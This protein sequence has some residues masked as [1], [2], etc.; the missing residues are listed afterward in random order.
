MTKV[1]VVISAVLLMTAFVFAADQTAASAGQSDANQIG[2]ATRP[3]PFEV[4]DEM[5]DRIMA[6]LSEQEPEKAKEL[7]KLRNE[8]KAKFMEQ[9]SQLFRE[10]M[11]ERMRP[12]RG[13]FGEEEQPAAGGRPGFH[14]GYGGGFG[15]QAGTGPNEVEM[16]NFMNMFRD[17]QGRME[18]PGPGQGPQPDMMRR[19]FGWMADRVEDFPKWLKDDYPEDA[20]RLDELQKK[21]P[22]LYQQ[23]SM[24]IAAKYWQEFE[25]SRDNPELAK[26]LKEQNGLNDN[27]ERILRRLRRPDNEQEK[28]ELI[29][30]LK[31]LLDRK[32]DLIVARKKI[33]YDR[34]RKKLEDLQKQVMESQTNVEKWEKLEFKQQ[35]VEARL[36][37]LVGTNKTFDWD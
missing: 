2:A 1:Y 16:Q 9:L 35:Q 31:K 7:E 29:G 4:P 8:D 32:Y 19:R 28:E 25:A 3:I 11:G 12:R 37:E 23:E 26:I 24:R 33:A 13:D 14:G 6:R 30:Q 22:G 27:Q 20:N 15:M 5:I 36:K 18:G 21:D 10:R 34:L 17:R